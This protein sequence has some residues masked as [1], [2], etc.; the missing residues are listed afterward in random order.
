MNQ[1]PET[2]QLNNKEN[3]KN[4]NY[5]RVLSL[6]R[7]NIYKHIINYESIKDENDYFDTDTFCKKHDVEKFAKTYC[8]Q[9]GKKI[10][11]ISKMLKTIIDELKELDWKCKLSFND[12]GLFIYSTEN[13]PPSCW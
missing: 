10:T 12:T 3:F 9:D 1:F 13:P 11:Y 4:L 2:L 6:L 5:D 7:E 8:E